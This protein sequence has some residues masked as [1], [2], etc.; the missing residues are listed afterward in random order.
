MPDIAIKIT[1]LTKDF[2]AGGFLKKS[3]IRAVD[4]LNLTV[5]TGEI[6]GLLG[7]NGAGKTTTLNM[8][9]G[10]ST[11]TSGEVELFGQKVT[12]GNIN[13]RSKI[14]YL[15]ESPYLPE[16]LSVG[17]F[18]NFY[19]GL[20]GLA[21]NARKE[22]IQMLLETVG[23]EDKR[24]QRIKTLS[25]GQKRSLNLVG[26]LINDPKML[27]LDEPT[28]YLDPIILERVRSIILKLKQEAKT[29]LISSHMLS[30]VER[31][32]DRIAIIHQAHLVRQANRE[33]FKAAGSLDDIFLS[34]IKEAKF[35]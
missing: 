2:P 5:N 17:E 32:C 15:P 7:P 27:I 30:E 25:I 11:P 26:A 34:S 23:L 21:A 12:P 22:R 16:Y 3:S 28:V 31:L 9:V 6:F 13:I 4:D 19:A 1:S 35:G 10:F 14:G 18:L 24:N 8:I 33:E 20:F 29:I